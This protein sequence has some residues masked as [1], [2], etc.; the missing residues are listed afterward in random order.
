MLRMLCCTA[1]ACDETSKTRGQ[2]QMRNFLT[3]VVRNIPLAGKRPSWNYDVMLAQQL[4]GRRSASGSSVQPRLQ[5]VCMSAVCVPRSAWPA[6]T[7]RIT[8]GSSSYSRQG[9]IMLHCQV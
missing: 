2:I 6:G 4:L 1:C 3:S 8:L 5:P 9:P 7:S